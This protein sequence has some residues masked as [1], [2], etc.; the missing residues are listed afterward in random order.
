MTIKR[1]ATKAPAYEQTDIEDKI[2]K[3]INRGGKIGVDEETS[4]SIKENDIDEEIRFTL[5]IPMSLIQKVD[6]CRKKRVGNIS[7][8]QW[9]IEAV[10]KFAE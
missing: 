3:V 2:G 9:I 10:N 1:K 7:R 6:Q 8:N 5:R 4:Q